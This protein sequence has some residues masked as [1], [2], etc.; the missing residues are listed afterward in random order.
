MQSNIF[1]E[2]GSL[3]LSTLNSLPK[4]RK[5]AEKLH[6]LPNFVEYLKA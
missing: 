5:H 6:A 3:K 1:E 2:K 4:L